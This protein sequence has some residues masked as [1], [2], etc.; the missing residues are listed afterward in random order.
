[1]EIYKLVGDKA[2]LDTYQHRLKITRDSLKLLQADKGYFVKSIEPD[3]TKHGV[4]GQE[5][6]GYL[7]GVANADAM[8]FRVTD[9][10][11]ASKIFNQ[12]EA[13]KDIRPFD[14]L[15]TNAPGLDD[16]YVNWGKTEPMEG[17]YQ[18]GQWVNGGVW[19]TVEG[20]AIMGYYRLGKF[21]D[22]RRSANRAMKWAKDFRMDAPWSQRGENTSNPW[23][24]TGGNQVGGVAVMVDNFASP[25][26][27]VRGL[28]EY[29]YKADKLTLYPHI[30][31]SVTSYIQKEPVWFG[32]K[33]IYLSI[34]NG[35]GAIKSV[36]VNGKSVKVSSADHF[37]L[38][39]ADLPTKAEVEIIIEGATT[40]IAPCAAMIMSRPK[41]DII[42]MPNSLKN[43][44]AVLIAMSSR[45][46][47]D[48]D[49]GYERVFLKEAIESIEAWRCRAKLDP[50]PGYFRAITPERRDGIQKFYENA[51]LTMYN[52]F[53]SRMQRYANSDN[54]GQKHIA[55]LFANVKAEVSR[56]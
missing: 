21:D 14:F 12:I 26:A 8:A 18:F 3:G 17:F 28:F 41:A 35:P 40:A 13:Y 27:T 5:K 15:L 46:K 43:P 20:R 48:K 9:D 36:K 24:D 10:K 38:S 56:Q 34:A 49:A 44:Y 22:I 37:S 33:S 6:Y 50:G 51:A 55:E 1:V 16:T 31:Q 42:D 29:I 39:Y 47:D 53:T 52:G 23:S 32:G 54:L 45:L 2:K 11:S 30:P 19:G 7:E 4:L 25:A